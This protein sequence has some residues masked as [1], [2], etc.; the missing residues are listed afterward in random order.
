M[1]AVRSAN[2]ALA[3]AAQLRANGSSAVSIERD[4]G[5]RSH[6]EREIPT[7]GLTA[8]IADVD[9]AEHDRE[10]YSSDCRSSPIVAVC[11]STREQSWALCE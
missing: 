8:K 3:R 9:D 2:P 11:D 7:A 6:A 4:A 1:D 10:R 5:K